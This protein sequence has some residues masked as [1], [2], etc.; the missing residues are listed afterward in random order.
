MIAAVKAIFLALGIGLTSVLSGLGEENSAQRLERAQ[1]GMAGPSWPKKPD[2][3]LSPLSGKMKDTVEISPRFYGKEK[4]FRAQAAAGWQKE[5]ALGKKN[6]WEGVAGRGWEEARWNQIRE[7][8]GDAANSGK[9]RPS[10]ELASEQTLAHRE[11]E[12]RTAPDWSSRPA[13]LGMG[14]EGSLHTYTGR[15]TR[16]RQQ[17]WQEEEKTPDL[18]PG[19]QE[20]FKP[21]EVE[22]MLSRPVGEFRGAAREQSATAVPLAA[23]DN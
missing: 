7:W 17:V 15:L 11:L 1:V 13:G 2:D 8:S 3:R 20:K 5:A 16:V 14:R 23:A 4:E 22:K 10:R 6:S 21:S 19:R 18:G 9:F 12:P